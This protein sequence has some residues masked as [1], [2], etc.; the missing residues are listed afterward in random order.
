MINNLYEKV[1][2]YTDPIEK[3]MDRYIMVTPRNLLNNIDN[4]IMC[5]E[6]FRA[7]RGGTHML[8][9]YKTIITALL[10]FNP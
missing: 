1:E 6:N 8:N 3:H 10:K 9:Y 4:T 5:K 2:K 7:T